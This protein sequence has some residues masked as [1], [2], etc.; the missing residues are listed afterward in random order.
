MIAVIGAG[1]SG[2]AAARVLAE[3]G[4]S[5]VV[6]DKARGVGGRCATR[7]IDGQP[8]DFGALWFHGEEP[9]FRAAFDGLPAGEVLDGWPR[10]TRGAGPTC[11]PRALDE[12]VP[13][14]ALRSGATAFPKHLARGLDVRTAARAT[15]VQPD[16]AGVAL[17]FEDGSRLVADDVV[18]TTPPEQAT[19]LLSRW[20]ASR[21]LDAARLVLR[22]L[23]T[24]ASLT[25]IATYPV[26]TPLPDFDV[27]HPDGDDVVL[28]VAHDSAKRAAPTARVM[29]VQATPAWSRAHLEDDPGAW[30]ASLIASASRCVGGWMERPT[31]IVAHRW[32]YARVDPIQAARGPVLLGSAR[33][34]VVLT[35][36]AF[37]PGSGVEGAFLAGRRAAS[38]LLEP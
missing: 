21:E 26:D 18:I 37:S 34:R 25:A 20:P 30:G 36:E 11:H 13:R 14:W 33:G 38:R 5:V 8:A 10:V 32:R 31:S 17:T 3:A 9:A 35:G 7:R 1:V 15:G 6:F 23:G 2:L 28:V 12:G 4:R 24:T 27:L 22:L 29:V 19:E 16:E